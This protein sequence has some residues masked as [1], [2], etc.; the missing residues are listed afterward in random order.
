MNRDCYSFVALCFA[1]LTNALSR[2]GD[3]RRALAVCDEAITFAPQ[4][5]ALR[6]TRGILT[7]P[8]PNAVDDFRAAIQLGDQHYYPHYYLAHHSILTR[9]FEAA[10]SWCRQALER[11]PDR[12]IEAQLHFWLAIAQHHL[13]ANQEEV[14]RLLAK[15]QE[16]DPANALKHDVKEIEA[17]LA[18]SESKFDRDWAGIQLESAWGEKY[19]V[20]HES[21]VSGRRSQVDVALGKVAAGTA[22]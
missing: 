15:A 18:A 2:W 22:A 4:S 21:M 16:I 20:A 9:N 5:Y 7:Y 12:P 13:G 11:R 10:V 19:T 1:A 17:Q 6:T 3:S 8:A 14:I